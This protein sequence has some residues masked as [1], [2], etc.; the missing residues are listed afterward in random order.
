MTDV[1]V[2]F[3][4]QGIWKARCPTPFCRGAEHH[5]ISP[6]WLGPPVLGGLG[7]E[8]FVCLQSCH[9]TYPAQWP[10]VEMREGIE[11]LL[12]LRPDPANRNWLPNETLSDLLLENAEHGI[13]PPSLPENGGIVL[14]VEGNRI[15]RG[16]E[17][18]TAAPDLLA[19]GGG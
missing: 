4:E 8:S 1:A 18:L 12:G 15:T 10:A 16:L 9:R 11:A 17:A 14:M 2:V 19:L 13:T 6:W 5:G 3:H 7:L